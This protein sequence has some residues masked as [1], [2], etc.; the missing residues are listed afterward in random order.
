MSTKIKIALMF[1]VVLILGMVIGF[2]LNMH[3]FGFHV[4]PRRM[5]SNLKRSEEIDFA[6]VAKMKMLKII[7]PRKDQQKEIDKIL[8]DYNNRFIDI[9]KGHRKKIIQLFIDLGNDIKP[10]LDEDQK[11]RLEKKIEMMKKHHS[12]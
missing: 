4:G 10:I 6:S 3:F 9:Q 7:K 11:K 12:D 1:I 2:F 5:M 8:E